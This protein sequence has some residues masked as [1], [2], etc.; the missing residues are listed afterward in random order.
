MGL[1]CLQKIATGFFLII[2][3]CA[4]PLFTAELEAKP[5]EP[6]T[7]NLLNWNFREDFSKGI[8]GWMSFPLAQDV[9]YDPSIYTAQRSGTSVLVRDVVADGQ[10]ELRVGIVRPL[11][12][13]ATASS[14]I[15]L[16]YNVEAT[17]VAR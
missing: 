16:G 15:Q 8:P 1:T 6:S 7:G 17:G 10:R 12:F 2:A 11:K 4:P 5:K 3:V 13:R 14:V 9:G